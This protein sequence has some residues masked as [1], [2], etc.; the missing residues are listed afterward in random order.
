MAQTAGTF[1][2][3]Y[4]SLETCSGQASMTLG[5]VCMWNGE[6]MRCVSVESDSNQDDVC[7]QYAYD[8]VAC[9]NEPKCFWDT[10]DAECTSRLEMEGYIPQPV[11]TG[12]GTAVTGTTGTGTAT[13]TATGTTTATG[14]ATGTT[15]TG[16]TGSTG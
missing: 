3:S 8:V 13:G 15:A 16:T 14:T 4:T 12:T 6:D 5:E 10:E 1:C 2:S 11:N 7:K 9:G